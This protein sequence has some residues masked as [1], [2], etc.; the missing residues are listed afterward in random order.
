MRL[1]PKNPLIVQ[2]SID[3]TETL[4]TEDQ[5]DAKKAEKLEGKTE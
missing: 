3:K 5:V 1:I 2:V 4:E